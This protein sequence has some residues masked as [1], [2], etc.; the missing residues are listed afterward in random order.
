MDFVW[1]L[2][3]GLL[4]GFLAGVIMKGGGFGLVGDLV[5][6]VLGAILGG[7]LFGVLGISQDG[8]LIGALVTALV[9][10]IVLIA[11]VRVFKKA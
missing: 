11:L 7:W 5:L 8:S 4:A 9:G 3:I 10:A 6:G 1:F 2:L